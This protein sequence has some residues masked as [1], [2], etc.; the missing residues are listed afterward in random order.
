M[1]ESLRGRVAEASAKHGRKLD[2]H[3]PEWEGEC[4]VPKPL[5]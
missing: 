3:P 5:M 2:A 4:L 1:F